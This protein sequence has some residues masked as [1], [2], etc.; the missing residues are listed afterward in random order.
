M[1]R[2]AALGR[3]VADALKAPHKVEIPCLAAEFAVGEQLITRRLLFCD[4]VA[5]GGVFGFLQC[6]VS[7]FAGFIIGANLLQIIRTQKA[8]DIIVTI[9]KFDIFHVNHLLFEFV[10]TVYRQ[11]FAL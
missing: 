1:E 9:R 4:K 2:D 5:N 10:L 11:I 7:G 6:F 3:S 8:A